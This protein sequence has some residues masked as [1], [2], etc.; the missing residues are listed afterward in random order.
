MS[1]DD[2]TRIP[3]DTAVSD[4]TAVPDETAVPDDTAAV[5][6]LPRKRGWLLVVGGVAAAVVVVVAGF[7][8]R[9][10]GGPSSADRI[11]AVIAH[12]ELTERPFAGEPAGLT[13]LLVGDGHDAVLRGSGVPAPAGGDVYQLWQLSPGEAPQRI[14]VFRPDDGGDV[15]VLLVGIVVDPGARFSISVEPAGGVDIPTGA[16]TAATS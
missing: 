5:S 2:G 9:G 12:P 15:E 16:M 6:L 3:D 1:T 10:G 7:A 14:E 8:I 4:D 11:A 13:L